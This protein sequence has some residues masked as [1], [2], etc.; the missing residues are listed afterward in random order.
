V[1][2]QVQYLDLQRLC[3]SHHH[4][5]AWVTPPAFDP[6]EV[7]EIYL[8]LERNLFLRQTTL[9]A[10]PANVGSDDCPPVVHGGAWARCSIRTLG[11]IIPVCYA[12]SVDDDPSALLP[13]NPIEPVALASA[14][15]V[16]TITLD[17]PLAVLPGG[18][19][20]A[21][22]AVQVLLEADTGFVQPS[23]IERRALTIGFAMAG[24]VLY[25]AA[26]DVVQVSRP[27][28]L[29]APQ[30]IADNLD[31]LTVCEVKSTSKASVKADFR[32]YFFD[33]TT[34]EL[35]VA[36]SLGSQY[37]FA[38]VNTITRTHIELSLTELFARARKIYPKWAVQF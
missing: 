33:L 22:R 26:F 17:D 37:K 20:T 13:V 19:Q 32:G 25:G 38:F 4:Q 2:Q 29:S 30:N 24:K 1:P 3:N 8:R 36:Q 27:V 16:E 6:A 28:D 31:A 7:G 5:Q 9:G 23:A 21:K 11:T 14:L 15:P 18:Q 34:A 10:Q 35:L 12:A